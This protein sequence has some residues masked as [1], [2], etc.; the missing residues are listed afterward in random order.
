MADAPTPF[1]QRRAQLAARVRDAEL[2]TLLISNLIHVRYLT[3][4]SGSNAALTVSREGEARIATD[5]RYT[6]QIAEEVPDVEALIARPSAGSL[7]K[8]L[9]QGHRVGFEADHVN[10]AQLE[11]WNEKAAGHLTLSSTTGM[12]ESLRLVKDS[13]EI[14]ALT[15]VANVASTAFTDLLGVGEIAAGRSE[16]DIAADLEYRMRR[17]GSEH[18]SFDTIVASGP[19]SAKPHHGAG[20]RVLQNGDLVTLDFGAYI[21]GFNSDMTRTVA[22]GH[23]TDFAAEIYEIV[24]RAQLAGV[25][26]STPGADLADVDAACRDIIADAGYAEQFV[27]STG[28]GVGLEV[29]EAPSASTRGTGKLA[30]NMTLTIEPGIYV[31]GQG[32]VRIEDTLVITSGAA[33]IITGVNKELLVV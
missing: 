16:R 10:V 3:G 2:D 1:Q 22:V 13:S 28:H 32:G 29:H 21:D 6:T 33:R 31:P 20:D 14:E 12:V 27:H 26:A 24:L 4:F 30:E 5:G 11:A 8:K 18:T 25:A 15:A 7:L 19:N 23:V 17:L 9:P